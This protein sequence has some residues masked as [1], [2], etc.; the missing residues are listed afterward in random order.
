MEI[1][2][3][4]QELNIRIS[5]S[6]TIYLAQLLTHLDNSTKKLKRTD[7]KWKTIKG[8]LNLVSSTSQPFFLILPGKIGK[9][10]TH[11][12]FFLKDC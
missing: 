4:K 11:P 9:I 1:K 6:I 5:E 7:E 8:I 3:I 2:I 10:G 12:I